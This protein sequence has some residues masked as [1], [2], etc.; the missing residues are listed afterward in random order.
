MLE[1]FICIGTISSSYVP[2]LQLHGA[3]EIFYHN[4]R[5]TIRPSK[6]RQGVERDMKTI[7]ARTTIRSM[8]GL[9]VEVGI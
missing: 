4:Y 1:R 9:H 6:L 5:F 2:S 3:V 7:V 8:Q